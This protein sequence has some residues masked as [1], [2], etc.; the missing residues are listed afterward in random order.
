[1]QLH[2]RLIDILK[3]TVPGNE[4]YCYIGVLLDINANI[5]ILRHMHKLEDEP[6]FQVAFNY[7]NDNNLATYSSCEFTANDLVIIYFDN[8]NPKLL[9]KYI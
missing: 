4:R 6:T 1:V 3:I 9:L 8:V 7:I 2:Y 5:P